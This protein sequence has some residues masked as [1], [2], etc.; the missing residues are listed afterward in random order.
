[1]EEMERALN[2]AREDPAAARQLLA[3][4]TLGHRTQRRYEEERAFLFGLGVPAGFLPAAS[5]LG[6]DDLA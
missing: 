5:A 1:M 3:I 4:F 6:L 2:Q